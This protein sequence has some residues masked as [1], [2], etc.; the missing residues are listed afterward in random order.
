[1]KTWS[2]ARLAF[3]DASLSHTGNG[4]YGEMWSAGLV[5]AAFTA[6]SARAAVEVSLGV[7]PPGS[8]MAAAIRHV[9]ELRD[10]GLSWADARDRIGDAYGH[11]AWVH[12]INN[13]AIV[14]LG[15]LW[16]DGDF[17]TAVGNT[18]M[19]GLD[20]DS[21]GATV[22]SVAGILAGTSGLP[23][24]LIE[25]LHNRTRSALFGFDNSQISDLADRTVA[26]AVRGIGKGRTQP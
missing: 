23:R 19:A 5:A 12:T 17:T 4:I 15:L 1:M 14:V 26:L 10:Q 18:V 25:P 24:N 21:N 9:L 3:Q 20:T 2:A 11:Y 22:G 7:I 13:A 8:R 6:P 16:S